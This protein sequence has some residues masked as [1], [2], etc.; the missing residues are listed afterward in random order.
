MLLWLFLQVLWVCLVCGN[1]LDHMF[2][3]CVVFSTHIYHFTIYHETPREEEE[4]SRMET[5]LRCW[6]S[7]PEQV[8]ALRKFADTSGVAHRASRVGEQKTGLANR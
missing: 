1:P 2:N 6:H 5:Q 7:V 3:S 4:E 8:E